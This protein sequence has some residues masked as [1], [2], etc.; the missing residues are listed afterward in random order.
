MPA[1][2]AADGTG[3]LRPH[4]DDLPAAL[5]GDAGPL[6]R[7]GRIVMEIEAAAFAMEV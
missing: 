6:G 2:E 7:V 4:E 1:S 3:L 5:R